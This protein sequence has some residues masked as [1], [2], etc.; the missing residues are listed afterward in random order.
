[1][2]DK[3]LTLRITAAMLAGAAMSA[4]STPRGTAPS[5]AA[6]EAQPDIMLLGLESI[7]PNVDAIVR[8]TATQVSAGPVDETLN[9]SLNSVVTEWQ[10][11]E[12]VW[13]DGTAS[14]VPPIA[15]SISAWNHTQDLLGVALPKE[16]VVWLAHDPDQTALTWQA[17]YVF[18]ATTMVPVTAAPDGVLVA[19]SELPH[20]YTPDEDT[21]V[22][23]LAAQQV[24]VQEQVA[25]LKARNLQQPEPSA[26]RTAALR[27]GLAPPPAPS[28]LQAW[29]QKPV[30]LRPLAQDERPDGHGLT[31]THRKFILD[32][33]AGLEST[34]G[35]IG[36]VNV[37]GL[38]QL[39]G[40]QP[41]YDLL[42]VEF[43]V[44]EGE[45]LR[46]GLYNKEADAV[47][48][49]VGTVPWSVLQASIVVKVDV[50]ASGITVLPSTE[51]AYNATL[52]DIQ[53][54]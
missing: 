50:T 3:T 51:S 1:M 45:D 30:E 19:N 43:E 2:M 53:F 14:I 9:I 13:A 16:V 25:L 35:G 47:A 44:V 41:K 42:P 39:Q 34:Y 48:R 5:D 7:A 15:S 52:T 18:D 28:P 54:K 26:P 22:E 24:F 10:A 40:I 33:E 23:K 6:P 38:A 8:A 4:C 32:R 46:V 12:Q 29:Q 17:E 36:F 11:T 31:L 49:W 37:S 21:A 20:L 27:A